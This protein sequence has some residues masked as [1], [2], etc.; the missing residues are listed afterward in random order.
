M[1]D[2][3]FGRYASGAGVAIAILAGC[4]GAPQLGGGAV[5]LVAVQRK[6]HQEHS[7]LLVVS[8]SSRCRTELD[9]SPLW[10]TARPAH[11]GT[12]VELAPVSARAVTPRA[13]V[14]V[15]GL[16]PGFQHAPCAR[17]L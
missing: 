13:T 2:L 15:R 3:R 5:P 14:H 10:R 7:P 8:S 1:I 6:Q 17:V 4:G 11:G 16:A 12:T 9:T